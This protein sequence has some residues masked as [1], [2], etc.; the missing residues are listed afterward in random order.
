MLICHR[1]FLYMKSPTTSLQEP[2]PRQMEYYANIFYFPNNSQKEIER[3]AFLDQAYDPRDMD[4]WLRPVF[5]RRSMSTAVAPINTSFDGRAASFISEER[6]DNSPNGRD[7]ANSRASSFLNSP[8]T[9]SP[10]LFPNISKAD[11]VWN[12]P[13]VDQMVEMLKVAMMTQ[14][15]MEPLPIHYNS[16][17]LHILEAY[18]DQKIQIQANEDIVEGLK[19]SHTKDI[20]EFEDIAGRWEAKEKDY[21]AEV[22]RLEI[23]L[24][25][26]AGGMESVTL[27]RTKSVVHGSK[28]ASDIIRSEI[29]SIKERN[30]GDDDGLHFNISL[31]DV[32]A[33]RL[34]AE[35]RHLEPY[36]LKD[37]RELAALI[38]LPRADATKNSEKANRVL[39][40]PD[41]QPGSASPRTTQARLVAHEEEEEGL[42]AMQSSTD[43]SS[44]GVPDYSS[45]EDG[46]L[47]LMAFKASDLL[48]GESDKSSATVTGSATRGQA[49][50]DKYPGSTTISP[51]DVP[52]PLRKEILY[53]LLSECANTVDF[54]LRQMSFSFKP[55][56]DTA[57]DIVAH[58]GSLDTSNKRKTMDEILKK[59]KKDILDSLSSTLLLQS[60]S[61]FS[62][63]THKPAPLLNKV[64]KASSTITLSQPQASRINFPLERGDSGS[65]I[66]TAVRDNSGRSSVT[67]GTRPTLRA[68]GRGSSSGGRES[69]SEAVV[70][71]T[72]AIASAQKKSRL[73]SSSHEELPSTETRSASNKKNLSLPSNGKSSSETRHKDADNYASTSSQHTSNELQPNGSEE[74]AST[75]YKTT[76]SQTI[77]Q[78]KTSP[79]TERSQPSISSSQISAT[80]TNDLDDIKSPVPRKHPRYAHGR[81]GIFLDS[82]IESPGAGAFDRTMPKSDGGVGR[83]KRWAGRD[84]GWV[85]RDI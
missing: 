80:G 36:Q 45:D 42:D 33:N 12:K 74:S 47:P 77:R 41:E 14:S 59:K 38:S 69:S 55:G 10:D 18:Y 83:E 29:G 27:A 37:N 49:T 35:N 25:R 61:E 19:E 53:T 44:D 68:S 32:R 39:G 60:P 57:L 72:R 3:E 65:S 43:S 16:C 13:S 9:T 7:R 75:T 50:L 4:S 2:P 23:L 63:V 8:T 17:I 11:T 6:A 22:R 40:I 79:A 52:G 73:S 28:K 85:D 5:S 34:K 58:R 62:S 1:A 24:S 26:T 78:V 66:V 21:Q 31:E 67:S 46:K 54:S 30:Y 51:E 64:E 71:A 81:N 70:A 76:M 84:K 48:T 15:S 56:D 20:K 82:G